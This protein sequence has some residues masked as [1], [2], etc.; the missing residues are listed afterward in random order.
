DN[1]EFTVDAGSG[2]SRGLFIIKINYQGDFE[3]AKAYTGIIVPNSRVYGITLDHES[4]VYLAGDFGA[5]MDFDPGQGEYIIT[6]GFGGADVHGFLS[7]LDTN[8]EFV[9]AKHIDSQSHTHGYCIAVSEDMSV[10]YSGKSSVVPANFL[11]GQGDYWVEASG[12]GGHLA[13]F[14]PCHKNTSFQEITVCDSL[15]ADNG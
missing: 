9:W 14:Q 13:K 15:V 11:K 6:Q 7:K 12:L 5:Q 2:L 10:Y 4:S 3:W 1:E 8:G